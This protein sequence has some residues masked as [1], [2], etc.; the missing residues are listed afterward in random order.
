M[1]PN[2]P[3]PT[4]GKWSDV[5]KSPAPQNTNQTSST[6]PNAG[7]S[8]AQPSGTS[9][10][11]NWEDA[12]RSPAGSENQSTQNNPNP[13][14]NISPTQ[15][16]P[17][18]PPVYG[19]T[20]VDQT[21]SGITPSAMSTKPGAPLPTTGNNPPLQA[22]PTQNVSLNTTLSKSSNIP[23]QQLA[24]KLDSKGN[25]YYGEGFQGLARSVFSNMFGT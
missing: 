7:A 20:P 9:G 21:A 14:Q 17:N 2:N 11:S 13:N 23:T 8:G 19:G 18:A 12:L 16:T 22:D 5:L 3:T 1:F 25:A 6:N 10:G 4:P 15:Q 24:I